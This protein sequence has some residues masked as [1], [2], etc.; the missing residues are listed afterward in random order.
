M[1][2]E[3]LIFST[4]II[5]QFTNQR[6]LVRN[7]VTTKKQIG[8]SGHCSATQGVKGNHRITKL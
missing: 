5:D 2:I 4:K 1:C 7:P 8:Q 3:F 6:R